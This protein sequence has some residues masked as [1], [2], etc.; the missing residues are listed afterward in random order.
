MR[1]QLALLQ[2]TLGADAPAVFERLSL[3]AALSAYT[4]VAA[5]A[6]FAEDQKGS[7]RPGLL[8]D[9]VILDRDIFTTTLNNLEDVKVA[10]TV[11]GGNIVF[12][13]DL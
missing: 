13:N 10:Y 11:L 9:L 2:H 5:Y 12:V 6:E 3:E 1:Q 4:T 7:L 8:G